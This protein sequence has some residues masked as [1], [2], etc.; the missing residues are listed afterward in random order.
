MLL[1]VA[2]ASWKY[3]LKTIAYV[4]LGLIVLLVRRRN[5]KKTR[6]ELDRGTERLMAQTPKDERGKYPWEKD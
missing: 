1:L 3:T 6:R 2:Y 5:R 4:S